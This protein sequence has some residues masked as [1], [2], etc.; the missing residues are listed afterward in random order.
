MQQDA[1][2]HTQRKNHR[3]GAITSEPVDIMIKFIMRFRP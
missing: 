1:T 2:V 3:F